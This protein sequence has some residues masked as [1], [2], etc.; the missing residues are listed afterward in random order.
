MD[1]PWQSW[2]CTPHLSLSAHLLVIYPIG[3]NLCLIRITIMHHVNKCNLLILMCLCTWLVFESCVFFL[4]Y[5]L[6]SLS[7]LHL[8][9]SILVSPGL[10]SRFLP[11]NGWFNNGSVGGWTRAVQCYLLPDS[12]FSNFDP[13]NYFLFHWWI[14]NVPIFHLFFPYLLLIF[15]FTPEFLQVE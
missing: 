11:F 12:P 6:C 3:C 14:Y 9:I 5:L 4:P 8:I 15:N 13:L 10:E 2:N 7:L 1:T